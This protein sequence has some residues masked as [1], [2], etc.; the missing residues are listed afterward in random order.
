MTQWQLRDYQIADGR[1]DDFIDAWTR[2][3]LSLRRA[4]GFQVEAWSVPEES[5]FIWILAYDGPGSFEDA[6]EA[7]YEMPARAELDPDPAQWI[8]GQRKTTLEPVPPA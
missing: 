6:D 5:R 2:G 3:V 4:A 8:V 7:Y 1:L